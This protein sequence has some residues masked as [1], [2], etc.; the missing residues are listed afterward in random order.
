[1]P[2]S[3]EAD[4]RI[5]LACV[6]HAA[7][8]RSEPGSNSPLVLILAVGHRPSDA[9]SNCLALARLSL[10]ELSKNLPTAPNRV[11]RLAARHLFAASEG[12]LSDPHFLSSFFSSFFTFFSRRV[13]C[14]A[15]R[16]PFRRTSAYA[17]RPPARM[18]QRV[19]F[20]QPPVFLSSV[21]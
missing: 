13:V 17:P 11:A 7:S 2:E 1:M 9:P 3:T 5:R 16:E 19:R 6:R 8:V 18:R 14:A 20:C 10:L 21:F 12:V 15:L 4:S